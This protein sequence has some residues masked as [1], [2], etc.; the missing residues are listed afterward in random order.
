MRNVLLAAVLLSALPLPALCQHAEADD[1]PLYEGT[2]TVRLDDQ[3]SARFVLKDWEGTWV[4]TGA[5]G[6][7]AHAC[8]GRKFPVTVQHS[9]TAHLEFTVWG[10]SIAAACPDT[11]FLLEPAGVP[12]RLEGETSGKVK[13]R[14]T[15]TRR[16]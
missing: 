4:E 2:W 14:M 16:G 15:R 5:A 12:D 8:R 9:T 10:S 11:S 6:T 3:R 1:V 7:V 13:V